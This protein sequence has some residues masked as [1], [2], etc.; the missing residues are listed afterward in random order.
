MPERP[1]S[2]IEGLRAIWR[3]L[4][5]YERFEQIVSRVVMLLISAVIVYSLVLTVISLFKQVTFEPEFLDRDALK[6]VFG[7]ILTILI[8]IEFNHSIAMALTKK[9][10]VLQ[11]RH[12]VLIAILVIARKVILLDF[13]T[14]SFDSLIGIAGIAVGIGILYW[15]ITARSLSS[16]VELASPPDGRA[17]R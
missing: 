15:L 17:E 1:I 12:V 2:M 9:S 6:D 16:P 13:A 10:G 11:A 14:A 8:L 4:S 7:M 5:F 3:S